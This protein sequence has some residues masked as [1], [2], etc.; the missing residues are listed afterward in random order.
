[1]ALRRKK[2]AAAKQGKDM[3]KGDLESLVTSGPQGA[4]EALQLFRSKAQRLRSKGDVNGAIKEA[5]TGA[6]SLLRH[7]YD[8]AGVE[9]NNLFLEI[10]NEN[11]IE[12]NAEIRH[13]IN[14]IDDILSEKRTLRLEFLKGCVKWTIKCG[15][16]ELGDPKLHVHLAMCLWDL[17]GQQPTAIYHFAAGEDSDQVKISI[18]SMTMRYQFFMPIYSHTFPRVAYSLQP[19]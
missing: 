6:K 1:M 2:E 16:R 14:E 5:A 15:A 10:L 3:V 19:S 4:Y 17:E 18:Y 13:I 9:M 7:N 12:I 11:G 8:H